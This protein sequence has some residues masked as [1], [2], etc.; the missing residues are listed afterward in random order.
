LAN[1]LDH[2]DPG[3][4]ILMVGYGSGAGSDAFDIE[5]TPGIK[6][7]DRGHGPS[8]ESHLRGGTPLNYA[9]YAKFRGKIHMGGS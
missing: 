1:V 3:E 2:A 6:T 9:V 4:R 8:V 7:Y 5:T